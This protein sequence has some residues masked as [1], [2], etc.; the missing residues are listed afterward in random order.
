MKKMITII[1]LVI[2]LI[3]LLGIIFKQK[4]TNAPNEQSEIPIQTQT[5]PKAL[6]PKED[7][8]GEVTVKVTPLEL[9][10]GRDMVFSVSLNTH[11]VSLSSSFKDN[12]FVV[13]NNNNIYKPKSWD[14]EE[15]GHHLNGKLI[16]APLLKSA[17]EITFTIK[18]IGEKD[19]IFKW[20]L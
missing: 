19:R 9:S 4:N 7:N 17:K 11:S 13:D 5:N 1:A 6:G 10:G 18:G 3:A 15:A 2:I 8:Q 16:F 12:S 20:V 14:G